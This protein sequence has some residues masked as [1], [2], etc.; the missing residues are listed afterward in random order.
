V[1]EDIEMKM[2][3]SIIEKCFRIV[4]Q[5]IGQGHG[6]LSNFIEQLDQ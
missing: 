3:A 4:E 2:I 1:L 6:L 5:N